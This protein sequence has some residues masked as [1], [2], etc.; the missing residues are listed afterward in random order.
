MER[1]SVFVFECA[2][3]ELQ[4]RAIYIPVKNVPT[5]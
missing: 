3:S 5:I 4:L 2:E 1:I